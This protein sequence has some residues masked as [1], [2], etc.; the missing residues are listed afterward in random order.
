MGDE[1]DRKVDPGAFRANF[2][3]KA[4]GADAAFVEDD[5]QEIVR[6][7]FV[8]VELTVQA[9]YWRTSLSGAGSAFR[10]LCS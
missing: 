3:V 1:K 4:I 9:A 6:F 5:W 8:C 10:G 2:V 7:S